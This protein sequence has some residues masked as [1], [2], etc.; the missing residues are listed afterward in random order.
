[1]NAKAAPE[2]E[3][4]D[5][6]KQKITELENRIKDLEALLKIYREPSGKGDE[7]DNGWWNS[8]SWR[9]LKEGM[10]HE[11]VKKI[12]GEPVK[13]I[14]GHREIWYYPHLYRSYVSFDEDGNLKGWNE[15]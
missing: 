9:K 3:E 8:K 12:L 2:N 11:Q 15:P 4:I 5:N 1:M 7:K 10:S 13:A 6:L 14:K